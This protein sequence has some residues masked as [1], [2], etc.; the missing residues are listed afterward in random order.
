MNKNK[1]INAPYY[2]TPETFPIPEGVDHVT[3]LLYTLDRAEG[4]LSLLIDNTKGQHR[5]HAVWAVEGMIRQCKALVNY[6]N[7]LEQE[8]K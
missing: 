8:N 2:D 6:W 3:S 4:V 1:V 7:N 5:N